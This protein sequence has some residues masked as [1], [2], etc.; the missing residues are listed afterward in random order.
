M[1]VFEAG[2]LAKKAKVKKLLLTHL[3]AAESGEDYIKEAKSSLD[4][5]EVS[6]ILKNY[7]I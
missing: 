3:F 7:N 1:T 2:V 4:K 6:Q 5:V